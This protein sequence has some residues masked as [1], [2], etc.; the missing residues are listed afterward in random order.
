MKRKLV[1]SWKLVEHQQT[2]IEGIEETPEFLVVCSFRRSPHARS[3]ACELSRIP[4][5]FK[6]RNLVPKKGGWRAAR[7]GISGSLPKRGVLS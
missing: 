2:A 4:G 7:R 3:P 5:S 1:I 6:V